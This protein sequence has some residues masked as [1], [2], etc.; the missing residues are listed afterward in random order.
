VTDL[1]NPTGS[2]PR[3]EQREFQREDSHLGMDEPYL[4]A[5]KGDD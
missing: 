2:V 1:E 4:G 5:S 3:N